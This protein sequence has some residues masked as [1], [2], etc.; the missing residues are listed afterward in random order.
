MH[1]KGI[2]TWPDGRKYEGE[3]IEDKK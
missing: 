1:G 2:F 3:Y